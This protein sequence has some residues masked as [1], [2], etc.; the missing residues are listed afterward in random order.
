MTVVSLP[1]GTLARVRVAGQE[2][3]H[4]GT[5]ANGGDERNRGPGVAWR[6][7]NLTTVKISS[8][9]ECS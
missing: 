1:E 5:L 8:V 3:R 4:S 6:S 9:R 2:N 7:G